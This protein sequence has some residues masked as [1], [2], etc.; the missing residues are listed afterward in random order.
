M[1][2]CLEKHSLLLGLALH[3]QRG[4]GALRAAEAGQ[5]CCRGGEVVAVLNQH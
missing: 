2:I 1:L 4:V 3:R 5:T